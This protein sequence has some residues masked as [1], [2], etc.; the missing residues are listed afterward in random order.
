MQQ[1]A[2]QSPNG[3]LSLVACLQQTHL[4]E[5]T[6]RSVYR[7]VL[8]RWNAADATVPAL[9]H[10]HL[11]FFLPAG[12]LLR[13]LTDHLEAASLKLCAF[14]TLHLYMCWDSHMCLSSS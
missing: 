8:S 9:R 1:Q 11:Q 14:P 10:D 12:D 2:L 5:L 7:S 13:L 3:S 6:T 4:T